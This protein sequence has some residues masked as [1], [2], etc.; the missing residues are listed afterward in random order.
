MLHLCEEKIITEDEYEERNDGFE[1]E[2]K[3]R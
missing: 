2:K 3:N 1:E